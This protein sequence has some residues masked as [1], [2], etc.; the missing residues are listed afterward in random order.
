MLRFVALIALAGCGRFGFEVATT[1]SDSGMTDTTD[2]VP[3]GHDEDGDGIPDASD[4]CPH[5]V[6]T[7]Q[8]DGDSDGVGD[9]C[10][11]N[12]TVAGD[13]IAHFATMVAGDQPLSIPACDSAV[14]QLPDAVYFDG[15]VS[16]QVDNGLYCNLQMPYVLA[17]VRVAVGF[18]IT[19]VIPASAPMQNQIALVVGDR[20]PTYF[21]EVNQV[22]GVVDNVQVTL[23][24]GTTYSTASSQ[25][26]ANG[27][28]T[29]PFIVQTTQRVGVGV[30]A[31]IGW[32]GEMYAAEVTDNVY[33]GAVRIEMNINNLDFE[34]RWLVVIT[35]P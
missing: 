30:R 34:L 12:P 27:V 21:V 1:G 7:S 16:M 13:A 22:V 33:Q 4:V 15:D 25:N 23:F 9:E 17:N 24:D 6:T 29:G 11:P 35:S 20:T 10:D 18:E 5:I 3:L 2:V 26:L 31:D 8:A 28:H 32:P 14:V 19:E